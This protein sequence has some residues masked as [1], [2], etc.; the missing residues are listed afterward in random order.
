MTGA[1][2]SYILLEKVLEVAGLS[3][4]T[5]KTRAYGLWKTESEQ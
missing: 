5:W 1:E 4:D 2:I 3:M